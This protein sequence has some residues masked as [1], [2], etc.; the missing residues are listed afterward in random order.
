MLGLL[1]T[2]LAYLLGSIPFG[3][4]IVRWRKGI[5]VRTTGSKSIGAT[6]VMRNLGIT[7]FIATFILDASKGFVSVM[8]AL[9]LTG[10]D[11]RWI[12]AAGLAAIS[13]HIFPIWLDF[14]GGKGVST[15][16]G[17]FF[18]LAPVAMGLCLVIFA[19]LVTLWRYISVASIASTA[20]FPAL[21]YLL[22]RP[23][24]AIILGAV[25]AAALIVATHR[26]N[27]SRLFNGTENKFG[28]KP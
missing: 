21:A 3:Y 9:I 23:P 19:V 20:A 2:V 8:L 26:A 4:L 25:T 10:N 12:A 18:A 14:R 15:S 11:P 17:V 5:D 24:F 22:S 13:G 27:L 6:N 28:W 7:G 16:V 1:A